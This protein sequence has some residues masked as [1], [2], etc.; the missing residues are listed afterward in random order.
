MI[1]HW[2]QTE[3]GW[4]MAASCRGLEPPPVKSGSPSLPVP[5]YRIDILDADG[6][7]LPA[8]EQGAIAVRLPLPPG[9]LPTLWN[10]DERCVASYLARYPGWYL[11]GDGGHLD[12][13]GYLFV[14]G[15]T[16]DVINVAGHRLSTGAMEEVVATHP[17]VAECAVF[18]VPDE[19]RGEVPLGLRR[20]Q[21]RAPSATP[22]ELRD[23]LVAL[24][25][26]RIGPVAC[27][28]DARVVARLPKTRSG[29]ILRAHD[30]RHRRGPRLRAAGDDRRPG[31]HRRDR[32]RARRA[33]A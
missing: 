11:T 8:G 20:A 17:D 13:D 2:W 28:R 18:G 10:D 9:A 32:R 26:E 1:D 6:A 3:T 14:M 33:G 30:A 16:D 24:V 22:R 27:F 5:G 19:L 15:R 31:D 25:R 23:E 29:K 21:G 7:A 12:E 4:A